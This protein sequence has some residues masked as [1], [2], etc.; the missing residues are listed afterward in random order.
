ML[1]LSK[2]LMTLPGQVR[3][4]LGRLWLQNDT[5]RGYAA[6]L[7]ACDGLEAIV[8][9]TDPVAARTLAHKQDKPMPAIAE[10]LSAAP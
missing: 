7:K 8:A 10:T 1:A 3:E 5:T 4:R 6:M 9:E 2:D